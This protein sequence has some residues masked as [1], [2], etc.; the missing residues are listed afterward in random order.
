MENSHDVEESSPFANLFLI[1]NGLK[2]FYSNAGFLKAHREEGRYKFAYQS[3]NS[4]WKDSYFTW[5]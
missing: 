3:N 2:C 1:T 4:A 5:L